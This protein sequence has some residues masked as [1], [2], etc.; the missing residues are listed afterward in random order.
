MQLLVQN[1]AGREFC[2]GNGPASADPDYSEFGFDWFLWAKLGGA[3][4]LWTEDWCSDAESHRWSFF[5]SRM[6]VVNDI[7][8][9]LS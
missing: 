2:A 7:F 8:R 9:T 6:L 5:A 1:F 4:L 3:S